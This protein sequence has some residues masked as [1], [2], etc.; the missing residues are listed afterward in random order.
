MASKLVPE[1]LRSGMNQGGGQPRPSN[2]KPE[3]HQFGGHEQLAAILLQ[4]ADSLSES[5][6]QP[7]VKGSSMRCHV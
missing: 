2:S 6:T 1:Q 7:C 5:F 4:F 3:V